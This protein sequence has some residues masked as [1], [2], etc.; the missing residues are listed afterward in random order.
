MP[1]SYTDYSDHT[2][3]FVKR[4]GPGR[5]GLVFPVKLFLLLK[6]IDLKE[7]HLETIISWN[8]HGR[9]FKIHDHKQF[10]QLIMPRFFGSNSSDTFRRQLNFWGFK[11]ILSS[12]A[13][14][15]SGP[16]SRAQTPPTE[17]GSYYHEKFLRSKDYL[18][19]LI[20]RSKASIN[21]LEPVPDFE[22]LKVLPPSEQQRLET[23]ES[24]D[25]LFEMLLSSSTNEDAG[26]RD[27]ANSQ[28][29]DVVMPSNAQ[30]TSISVTTSSSNPTNLSVPFN[31]LFSQQEALL[32][33]NYI[34]TSSIPP[35]PVPLHTFDAS[36]RPNEVVTGNDRR[37]QAYHNLDLQQLLSDENEWQWRHLQPFPI[38]FQPPIS[39]TESQE[40]DQ[41]MK[42]IRI[43]TERQY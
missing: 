30:A 18:C 27:Y 15:A 16:T 43:A 9:S 42:F 20:R 37:I 7:P 36:S 34:M 35:P 32:L 1:K 6:Y 28:S 33:N 5:K 2:D 40:M 4:N 8:H 17:N 3:V 25:E 38:G 41:F 11:R 29:S 12:A 39:H 13:S 31:T 10:R 19:R 24:D 21:P 26:D 22:L 14:S 23:P